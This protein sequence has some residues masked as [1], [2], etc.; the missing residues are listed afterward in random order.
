MGR[1]IQAEIFKLF[2]NKT[3]IILICVCIGLG[4]LLA[5][6]SS[7]TSTDMFSDDSPEISESTITEVP[8]QSPTEE[9]VLTPGNIGVQLRAANPLKPT[10]REIFHASFGSGIIEILIASLIAGIFVSEY[11][12]GTLKNILAYG[13]SRQKFYFAKFISAVFAVS[14]FIFLLTGIGTLY[15]AIFNGWREPFEVVHLLEML[16]TY[17]SV[18][19]AASSIIALIMLFGVLIK[20]P[21]GIVGVSLALF[22]LLPNTIGMNYGKYDWFDKIYEV[23]PFYNLVA[24]SSIYTDSSE[25]LLTVVVSLITITIFLFIGCKIFKKQDIK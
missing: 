16:G 4:S 15:S 17:T 11:K 18:V 2:K 7:D 23:T 8:T 10:V 22:L 19:F 1:L 25:K 21:N 13:V 3:F 5:F 6:M 20:T 9:P 12:D 14:I 24:S